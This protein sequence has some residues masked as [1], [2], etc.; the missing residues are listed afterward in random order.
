[1]QKKYYVL[2]VVCLF[3]V[4]FF[5]FW[6]GGNNWFYSLNSQIPER[7]LRELFDFTFGIRFIVRA[8][9]AWSNV[10]MQLK[11]KKRKKKRGLPTRKTLR[12]KEG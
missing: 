8:R 9:K 1:M 3:V 2:L 12:G 10:L 6:G 5:F 7:R 11:D 4:V